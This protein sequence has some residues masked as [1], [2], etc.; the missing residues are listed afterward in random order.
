MKPLNIL[1]ILIFLQITGYSAINNVPEDYS[2]NQQASDCTNIDPGCTHSGD[3]TLYENRANTEAVSDIKKSHADFHDTLSSRIAASPVLTADTHCIYC[4]TG[5]TVN[6]EL[7]ASPQYAY[8]K[9]LCLGSASGTFPGTELPGG[10]ILPLNWDLIT[11]IIVYYAF[12]PN[13]WFIDFYGTLDGFGKATAQFNLPAPPPGFPYEEAS[14]WFAYCIN[15]YPC[16]AASNDVQVDIAPEWKSPDGHNDPDDAWYDEENAY[17]GDPSTAAHHPFP[18][19]LVA[20]WSPWLELTLPKPYYCDGVKILAWKDKKPLIPLCDK[21]W[22]EVYH[23]GTWVEV[24]KG[25]YKGTPDWD[26]FPILSGPIAVT[27][28]KICFFG[29]STLKYPNVEADLFEFVFHVDP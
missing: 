22:I 27:K 14:L 17:D 2:T 15:D 28:A 18:I 29:K 8:H 21:V 26:E 13:P 24:H 16:W 7:N 20:D 10:A 3:L 4:E 12:I 1:L 11:D 25:E 23:E 5:G 9:Y 6:F 19:K